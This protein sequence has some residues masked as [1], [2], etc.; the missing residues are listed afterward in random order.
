MEAYN[1]WFKEFQQALQD[2]KYDILMSLVL[3][4]VGYKLYF[5]LF[6]DLRASVM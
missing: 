4:A 5:P 2:D 1:N 3:N 6:F